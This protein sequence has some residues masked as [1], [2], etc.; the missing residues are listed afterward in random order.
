MLAGAIIYVELFV[1]SR[2]TAAGELCGRTLEGDV[3]LK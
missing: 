2:A 3:N 1:D